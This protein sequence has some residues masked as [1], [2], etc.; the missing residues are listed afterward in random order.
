MAITSPSASAPL[1]ILTMAVADCIH[2]L[3][4]YRQGIQNGLMKN[5]ALQY[6]MRKHRLPI[7]LTSLTTAVGFLS[8]NFSD[9]PPF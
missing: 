8:M 9:S 2:F 6:S 3:Q 5:D 4:G 1:I 7:I